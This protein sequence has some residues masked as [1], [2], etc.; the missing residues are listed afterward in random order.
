M[1][2][3]N[4]LILSLIL[5][6]C[7]GCYDGHLIQK[8]HTKYDKLQIQADDDTK[9]YDTSVPKRYF[10][11]Y[12]FEKA[13]DAIEISNYIFSKDT[14]QSNAYHKTILGDE[15]IAFTKDSN[16]QAF[17]K[18]IVVEYT[19]R[20]VDKKTMITK[21]T[22]TFKNKNTQKIL[23]QVY[24]YRNYEQRFKI[25]K[26]GWSVFQRWRTIDEMCEDDSAI[27]VVGEACSCKT[28]DY[29]KERLSPE[30]LQLVEKSCENMSINEKLSDFWCLCLK[31]YKDNSLEPTLGV[32]IEWI[33]NIE[34][35]VW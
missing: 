1:K 15:V 26:L 22:F 4:L 2:I 6:L 35:V 29:L 19:E 25:Y 14:Q 24:D 31:S 8:D 7:G 27:G 3:T 32:P 30:T 9:V 20:R 16:Y 11:T 17:L 23:A 21:Q 13:L 34:N 5:V 10:S 33:E 28:G 12:F 18:Q